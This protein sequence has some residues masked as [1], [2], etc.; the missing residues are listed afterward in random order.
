[1]A[2]CRATGCRTCR[3]ASRAVRAVRIQS[4][5]VPAEVLPALA[6]AAREARR[7]SGFVVPV[8]RVRCR[9]QHRAASSARWSP[10]NPSLGGLSIQYTIDAGKPQGWRQ[11]VRTV[12]RGF[13]SSS[14]NPLSAGA[15]CPQALGE[16]GLSVRAAMHEIGVAGGRHPSFPG[17]V[18]RSTRGGSAAP[19]LRRSLA[20]PIGQDGPPQ[21]RVFETNSPSLRRGGAQLRRRT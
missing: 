21:S 2:F 12:G 5:Q 16:R 18:G 8:Q 4:R 13:Q 17:P 3:C 14:Q 11:F 19:R 20:L 6:D 15:L 9:G 10:S 1:M 7:R